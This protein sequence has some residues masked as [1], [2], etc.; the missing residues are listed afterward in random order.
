MPKDEK[1]RSQDEIYLKATEIKN[2]KKDVANFSACSSLFI[3]NQKTGLK[4]DITF[5]ENKAF[6]GSK[7]SYRYAHCLKL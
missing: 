6:Q 1:E 4:T 5:L 2:L 3:L 7:L